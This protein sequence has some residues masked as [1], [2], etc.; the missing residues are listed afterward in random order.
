MNTSQATRSAK[1]EGKLILASRV[2]KTPVYTGDRTHI[3]HVDDI[4]IDRVSGQSVYAIMSFGGFLGIG[5]RFH[6]LPW[7]MLRY[8]TD[9]GGYVVPIGEDE[10]RDA[11]HYTS[12]E[13]ERL[14]GASHHPFDKTISGYYG[15]YGPPFW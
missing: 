8:D 3:G 7:D 15:P 9:L 1:A 13:L 14:G 4:S 10:L 2:L 5:E 11:P 12:D 6:P